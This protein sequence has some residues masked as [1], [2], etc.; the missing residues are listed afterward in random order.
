MSIGSLRGVVTFW[1]RRPPISSAANAIGS[2]VQKIPRQSKTLRIKP[3]TVGPSAGATEIT[4]EMLPITTPRAAGGTRFSTVVMSS[5]IMMAVPLACTTRPP[6]SISNPGDVAQMSVPVVNRPIAARNSERVE[7]RWIRNPVTGITTAIVSRNAV[8]SHCPVVGWMRRSSI[9]RGSAT[10]MIVSL[11]ITT[12]ADTSRMV[13][14]SLSRAGRRAGS[15]F[16]VSRSSSVTGVLCL[17]T[18][19][20]TPSAASR[21]VLEASRR[22]QSRDGD[23]LDGL[24]AV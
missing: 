21:C 20:R 17:C 18:R 6:T 4:M 2:T 5:G 7:N 12:N 22:P 3:E 15:G 9:R 1:M 23:R 16:L 14:T 19:R 13:M 11:R 8:A 10:F 24:A